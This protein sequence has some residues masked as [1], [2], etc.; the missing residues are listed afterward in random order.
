VTW[1]QS[2]HGPV[3][4][5]DEVALTEFEF[6]F[7]GLKLQEN[8]LYAPKPTAQ[9]WAFNEDGSLPRQ[10]ILHDVE[11]NPPIIFKHNI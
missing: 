8:W 11:F 5:E 9:P 2:R 10:R 4:R 1:Y 3:A 7:D 6:Y